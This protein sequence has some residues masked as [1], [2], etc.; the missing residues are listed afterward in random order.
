MTWLQISFDLPSMKL[1]LYLILFY[2]LGPTLKTP[3]SNV[4]S[5]YGIGYLWHW[6][7]MAIRHFCAHS[8]RANR[9]LLLFFS[10]LLHSNVYEYSTTCTCTGVLDI[11][12]QIQQAHLQGLRSYG[13]KYR[14][15]CFDRITLLSDAKAKTTHRWAC[16]L[17]NGAFVAINS[18]I[19]RMPSR[20][21][22]RWL[23]YVHGKHHVFHLCYNFQTPF[24][25]WTHKLSSLKTW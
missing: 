2:H 1:S 4:I 6:I 13:M 7:S 5:L 20:N 21:P 3:T 16:C 11:F 23:V 9:T 8:Y 25:R 10:S 17:R 14:T 18:S 15:A 22:I 12:F 24:I 19:A